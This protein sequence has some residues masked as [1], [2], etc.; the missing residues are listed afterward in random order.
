MLIRSRLLQVKT[1]G[2]R[3]SL[4]TTTK[5]SSKKAI[6]GAGKIAFLPRKERKFALILYKH[7]DVPILFHKFNI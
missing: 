1:R 5:D 6:L 4:A 3:V 7:G 2:R